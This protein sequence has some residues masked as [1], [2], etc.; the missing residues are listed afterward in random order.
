MIRVLFY[1]FND[2]TNSRYRFQLSKK[3]AE[4]F[5]VFLDEINDCIKKRTEV[6]EC[7]F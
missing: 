4:R 6:V 1:V 2:L 7:E 5:A 3:E